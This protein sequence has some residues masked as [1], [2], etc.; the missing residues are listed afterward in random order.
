MYKLSGELTKKNAGSVLDAG[1]AALS[2]GQMAF[3]LAAL[4][5][6]DSSA[7]AVM[8]AWQRQATAKQQSIAFHDI[9]PALQSLISLYGLSEQF[10]SHSSERH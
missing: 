8:V 5:R 7:V 1:M 9:P 3:D 4:E 6:V 10:P 2:S